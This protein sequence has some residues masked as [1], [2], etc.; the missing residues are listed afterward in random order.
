[1]SHQVFISYSHI[2]NQIAYALCDKLETEG[3]KCWIAP[4]DIEPGK[5][6]AN[7]IAEAIPKSKLM[8]IILSS[9]SNASEQVLNEVEIAVHNKLIILPVRI[10][11]IMPTGGMSYYLATM[12]W[13]DIKGEEIDS[14]I[15]MISRRTINILNNDREVTIGKEDVTGKKIFA[16]NAK[17]IIIGLV[18]IVIAVALG[19][20]ALIFREEIFNSKYLSKNSETPQ[21][22]ENISETMTAA[23]PTESL[24][25]NTAEQTFEIAMITEKK[26]LDDDSFVYSAWVGIEEY[27]KTNGI[28]YNYYK[29]T[30]TETD[31]FITAIDAAILDGAKVVCA[32]G[33][34]FEQAIFYA[35]DMYPD[36]FF[37]LIDG[38]P[39]DGDYSKGSPTYEIADN[40]Y[41]V[42][43]AEQE[44][45]FFSWLFYC[46][47]RL[48]KNWIH[49]WHGYTSS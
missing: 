21:E 18:S 44:S 26:Y 15:S 42:V 24:P 46:E 2:D 1:M 30:E 36:T 5:K 11:D 37:I 29:P 3:I 33:F 25:D 43:F 28:T 35:Q 19:I 10:E 45:G 9:S 12:Q 31:A 40:C 38:T 13:I 48:Y 16:Y 17:K 41:S 22:T 27:G 32:P 14:K 34:L 7:E 39:N 20:T 49:R 8:I 23:S 4:R 6:W 47:R